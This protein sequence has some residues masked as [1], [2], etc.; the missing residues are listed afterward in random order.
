MWSLIVG[1]PLF[2]TEMYLSAGLQE[3][4]HLIHLIIPSVYVAATD[5]CNGE[6]DTRLLK[7]NCLGCMIST[8]YASLVKENEY[9][10]GLAVL[11]GISSFSIETFS[12]FF[13]IVASLL[14]ITAMCA[15]KRKAF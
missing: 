1:I 7:A 4:Y 14:N 2:A 8:I 13:P 15:L 10:I 9:G 12:G 3:K 11:Y 5:I 6:L